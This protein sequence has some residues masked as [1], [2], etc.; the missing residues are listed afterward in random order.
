MR[1]FIAK[2]RSK[3]LLGWS[4]TIANAKLLTGRFVVC[5]FVVTDRWLPIKARGAMLLD[6]YRC[7]VFFRSFF[8]AGPSSLAVR[9]LKRAVFIACPPIYDRLLAAVTGARGG[10]SAGGIF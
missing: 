3:V 8:Q 2:K 1:A 6:S 4:E 7:I 10:Q 5:R 9:G